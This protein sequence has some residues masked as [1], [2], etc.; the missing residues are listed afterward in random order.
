MKTLDIY[1][2]PS[3][4]TKIKKTIFSVHICI[5]IYI[6]TLDMGIYKISHASNALQWPSFTALE[7]KEGEV[8]GLNLG[9]LKLHQTPWMLALMLSIQIPGVIFGCFDLQLP[10]KTWF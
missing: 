4:E 6:L 2:S 7:V 10:K 1:F 3:G 5:Y 9:C 8:E